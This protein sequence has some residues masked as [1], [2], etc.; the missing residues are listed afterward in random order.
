MTTQQVDIACPKDEWLLI[1]DLSVGLNLMTFEVASAQGPR[2]P[3]ATTML[4]SAWRCEG[5]NLHLQMTAFDMRLVDVFRISIQRPSV[6]S[7]FAY[8]ANVEGDSSSH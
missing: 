8:P 6:P 5:D 3:D 4:T 1:S 2:T 7:M